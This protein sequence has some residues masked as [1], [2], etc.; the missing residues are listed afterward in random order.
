[1]PARQLDK[2]EMREVV[3]L[4]MES[5]SERQRLAVLLNKFEGM[6]YA[7][8]AEKH[9]VVAPGGQVAVVAGT[10]EPSPGVVAVFHRIAAAGRRKRKDKCPISMLNV[11]CSS[12]YSSNLQ[13]L[14]H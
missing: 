5:L 6:S 1:M 14:G 3:R 4:A 13:F 9:G 8:I 2:A 10:G 7:D 12:F 11:Q